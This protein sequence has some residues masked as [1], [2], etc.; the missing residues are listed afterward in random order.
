M[1]RRRRERERGFQ[2]SGRDIERWLHIFASLSILFG[3]RR[4]RYFLMFLIVLA[5][6]GF[7]ALFAIRKWNDPSRALAKADRLWETDQRVEAIAEYKIL[8]RKKD[9]LDPEQNWLY[10]HRPR[11]YRRIIEYETVFR[12]RD[13]ARDWIRDAWSENIR[14]LSFDR[15][16]TRAL[17]QEVVSEIK[18]NHRDVRYAAQDKKLAQADY[19]WENQKKAE[20]VRIYKSILR[21]PNRYR[22]PVKQNLSR[23]FSR[24][25]EYESEHQTEND[26]ASWMENAL[27]NDV[28]EMKLNDDASELWKKVQQEFRQKK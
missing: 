9:P 26:V 4:G 20:A 28:R 6:V 3:G 23:I 1:N 14:N 13:V 7:I 21:G 22:N 5:I 11:L 19:L 10:E 25:I 27:D 15:D 8:L 17:W 24:V 18:S 12:D 2:V 16:E